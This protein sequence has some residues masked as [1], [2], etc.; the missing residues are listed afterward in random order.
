MRDYLKLLSFL[1]AVT[2]STVALGQLN[3]KKG[4]I[5][6]H[7]NDT[8]YGR[9]ND[10]GA[11]R[12]SKVCVFKQS[13]KKMVKY[14]PGEI[15]AYRMVNDKFYA[16]KEIEIKDTPASVFLEVV[17]DGD[18]NLYHY[19]KNKKMAFYIE[20][21][22]KLI[23]LFN[24]VG[25]LT[26]N[27]VD[28]TVLIY[29][30]SYV[31]RNRAYLDSLRSVFKDSKKILDRIE[32]VYYKEPELANITKDYILEKC[33]GDN[34]INYEREHKMY[35][36]TMGIYSG[37]RLHQLEFYSN[38]Y[39][40]TEKSNIFNAVPIGVFFNFPVHLI[41]DQLSFQVEI[42][43]NRMVYQQ[44]F[45]DS[46]GFL[47]GHQFKIKSS[48]IG[49]PLLLKYEFG[50]RKIRPTI[51]IGKEIGYGYQSDVTIDQDA[52][53]KIHATQKGNWLGEIGLNCKI[54]KRFSIFADVRI[55][56]N[57][58]IIIEEQYQSTP[59]KSLIEKGNV[60]R[61]YTNL[62]SALLIGLE[63]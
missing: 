58:N 16:S 43:S 34:C 28:E 15:K 45:A 62:S 51:G 1:L 25:L 56:K 63:F 18:V 12:N 5:I 37:V 36:P 27:S 29:G 24:E 33:K 21:D 48:T 26:P 10:G 54:G 9:I 20:K 30:P 23:G 7:E 52:D 11:Y 57:D 4:Y 13:R 6:T 14:H 32:E 59:Y 47:S 8:V 17:V 46:K 61:K 19:W 44:D 49:M 41:S 35:K 31:V 40:Y 42:I 3:F 39:H 22:N 38:Y 2:F 55:Q 50:H 53:L 60:K